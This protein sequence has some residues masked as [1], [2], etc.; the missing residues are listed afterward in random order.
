MI[1]VFKTGDKAVIIKHNSKKLIG[2]IVII[3]LIGDRW[4]NC[5]LKNKDMVFLKQHQIQKAG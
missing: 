1:N 3:R 2:E 4:Y 5:E